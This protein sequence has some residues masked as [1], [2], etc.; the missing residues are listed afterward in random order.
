MSAE[1]LI[2]DLCETQE[3]D[4]KLYIFIGDYHHDNYLDIKLLLERIEQKHDFVIE[5]EKISECKNGK[6]EVLF[7]KKLN[8]DFPAR[9][10]TKHKE[11]FN[12]KIRSNTSFDTIKIGSFDVMIEYTT[13][14][15]SI[16]D[17]NGRMIRPLELKS[18]KNAVEKNIVLGLCEE[19]RFEGNMIIRMDSYVIKSVLEKI[20]C[21]IENMFK[22]IN[23]V[24]Q[25][26]YIFNTL[27][28]YHVTFFE[29][30]NFK[31]SLP[32]IYYQKYCERE[33]PPVISIGR[34]ECEATVKL[35]GK[36]FKLEFDNFNFWSFCYPRGTKPEIEE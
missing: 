24:R 29:T 18:K 30:I 31:K 19:Y 7:K 27:G 16:E 17:K 9:T 2:C 35:V 12:I 10:Y 28:F 23:I 1:P 34:Q 26:N 14:L 5:K 21:E 11:N 13:F 6:C 22:N 20:F 8:F 32:N 25:R 15:C 3:V 4:G 36:K 33:Y